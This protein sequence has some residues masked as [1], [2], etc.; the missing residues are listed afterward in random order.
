MTG[1]NFFFPANETT[2]IVGRSGS[3][4]STIGNL[5]LKYYEIDKGEIFIDGHSIQTL[6]LNWLRENITLVQQQSVLFNETILQNITF[7]KKGP[8]SREEILK[9]VD[10]A[11]LQQMLDELPDGLNTVIGSSGKSLSGGQQQRVALARARLRDSAIV[12]LDEATSALDQ[13]SRAMITENIRKWRQGK[14]TIII[15]HDVSRILDEEYVYVLEHGTIVQEGYCRSLSEKSDGTFVSF[16]PADPTTSSSSLGIKHAPLYPIAV[17]SELPDSNELDTDGGFVSRFLGQKETGSNSWRHSL[18]LRDRPI[19]MNMGSVWDHAVQALEFWTTPETAQQDTFEDFM[20]S[21]KSRLVIAT[22]DL[23][24]YSPTQFTAPSNIPSTSFLSPNLGPRNLR[25]DSQ[26]CIPFPYANRES[27]EPRTVDIQ[28]PVTPL[29]PE[30][31]DNASLNQLPLAR[32][33]TIHSNNSSLP[34]ALSTEFNRNGSQF[35]TLSWNSEVQMTPES[36]SQPKIGIRPTQNTQPN[37]QRFVGTKSLVNLEGER[38]HN[39]KAAS[40]SQ[41][42]RTI[43]P[44][45]NKNDRSILL[46]GFL[47]SFIVAAATPTFAY[48]LAQLLSVY[49]LP[50]NRSAIAKKWALILIGITV[51]DGVATFCSHLALEY[52]AQQWVNGLRVEALKRILAQPRSWFDKDRNSPDRISECLDRNA[53]EMRNLV[54]RFMGPIFISTW[55]M[56]ISVV[57]ALIISYKLTLVAISGFP[58]VYLSTRIYDWVTS[59]WE[60]RCNQV[61]STASNIFTET[62]SNIRVVRALTLEGYFQKKHDDAVQNAWKTGIR[63]GLYTGIMFGVIDSLSFFMVATIFRYAS[64]A[65]TSGELSLLNM[66]QVINLLLFGISNAVSLL[67]IVPQ[68]NSSR[69]TGTQMLYLA[70]LP[71]YGS[72]ETT[73]T[74]RIPTP[75]PVVFKDLSFTY[76]N[77][78]EGRTLDHINFKIEAGS[79]T[80]IVGASGSGKS[81]IASLLLGLYP[82]DPVPVK[83]SIITPAPLTFS[84]VS[85]AELSMSSLRNFICIVAQQ[86]LLFPTTI[87][88]NITYGL[89]ECSP[90]LSLPTAVLAAKDAGIHKFIESLPNGYNTRIGEGGMGISGGQAQ[91]IVIARALIRRPKILILDEATSAL[92]AVSTEAIKNSI[93]SMMEK[94]RLQY[95]KEHRTAVVIIS[96]DVEMMKVADRVVVIERGRVIEEGGLV[97]LSKRGTAF[98]ALIGRDIVEE[99]EHGGKSLGL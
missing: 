80:A 28:K 62:F 10:T 26:S 20:Q 33:K 39:R 59:K 52:A 37:P 7:G 35:R 85:I 67:N 61:A 55:L 82:P 78:S 16:L 45:L 81:T 90:Y 89:A 47:A 23:N 69:T 66:V 72:H 75:F 34:R 27:E 95:A 18:V 48:V 24:S 5:L 54:G 73:G 92:D 51:V 99:V 43:W 44:M 53:E 15:T 2:Y 71:T 49:Y 87:Y 13:K 30:I 38:L 86:P 84:G 12:I 79:C 68:I 88:E 60:D 22:P 40:I 96:H 83:A 58:V 91:R 64:V 42:I 21:P 56:G 50:S 1:V 41:I 70:Q 36:G 77:R 4:K 6:N 17:D 98:R 11:D 65:S 31:R 25:E 3:G 19:S 32:L 93:K 94:D 63:R 8:A 14:T 29:L 9:A 46:L 97:E 57:W 74:K 76:P